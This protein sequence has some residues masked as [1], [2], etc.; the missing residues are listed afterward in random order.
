MIAGVIRERG[1]RGVL[2]FETT[3]R[4]GR[5]L[6]DTGLD[7][8]KN[9]LKNSVNDDIRGL[10]GLH[11][12]FTINDET[13]KNSA[14][15]INENNFGIHIHLCEDKVD[16]DISLKQYN[17]SPV[18]RLN[19]FG[20]LNDKSILAHGIQIKENDFSTIEKA[21]SALVY[22]PDSNL[23]NAV[24][25]PDFFPV[26]KSIP[27]L[28]GTDGMNSNQ[29]RSLKQ[30]FLLSRHNGMSF[31]ESFKWII[32]IYFDQLNFVKKYFPDFAALKLNDRADFIVWD[33]IPPTP[34][35]SEN[36]WGHYVYGILERPI[37]SVVQNGEVLMNDFQITFDQSE[38]NK[39]IFKQ[40]KRLFDKFSASTQQQ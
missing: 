31:N 4:N 29:A 20:L 21:G 8:N 6:A 15:F 13:L 32:K 23:N 10:L 26:P 37:H 19:H 18:E 7:E 24:G 2:C 16:R 11:A 30:L 27:I 1:L 36:F 39:H 33:Y 38:Y 17:N 3:D 34:I 28:A 25:L 35:N 22:N 9:F 14:A 40:G 12:S 5:A